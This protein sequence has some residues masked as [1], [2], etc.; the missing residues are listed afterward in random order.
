MAVEPPALPPETSDDGTS[1]T[2]RRL[3]HRVSFWAVVIGLAL[4]FGTPTSP[5]PAGPVKDIGL[6]IQQLGSPSFKERED[7]ARTL[8]GIGEPALNALRDAEINDDPEV[9]RRAASVI[10]AIENDLYREILRFDGRPSPVWS[11]CFS[12][13]G[14]QALSSS[15]DF[16]DKKFKNCSVHLWD[17][18]TGKELRQFIGHES[19]VYSVAFSLD[20]RLAVSADST[21]ARLWDCRTGRELHSLLISNYRPAPDREFLSLMA[22]TR[23]SESRFLDE[24]RIVSGSTTWAVKTGE[25]LFAFKDVACAT[26]ALSPDRRLLLR[27]TTA[28]VGYCG[29]APRRVIESMQRAEGV[30]RL[31]EADTGKE[32]GLLEGHLGP[33]RAVAFCPDGRHARSAG[34]DGTVRQWDLKT[35]KEVQCLKVPCSFAQF[36]PDGRR[37]L[38]VGEEGP[39][40]LWDV[41]TGKAIRQFHATAVQSVAFSP[42]GQYAL[43]G[44]GDGAIRLWRLPK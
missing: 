12:P 19:I 39:L 10:A 35:Q 5:T 33:L 13:D 38:T 42:D 31:V 14:R 28:S 11:L 41:K 25:K 26:T 27:G 8:K 32:V 29:L 2:P 16:A 43:S 23:S 24:G 15:G 20:G 4:L 22:G 44:G 37:L 17:V 21:H 36:S 30:I 7:A 34:G 18:Q 6:L 1:R 9:R 3:F 40:T